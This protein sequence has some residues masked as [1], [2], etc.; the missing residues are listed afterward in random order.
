MAPHT[1]PISVQGITFQA[2]APYVAGHVLDAHEAQALNALL[3]ENLRNNWARRLKGRDL[4]PLTQLRFTAETK[5]AF[6]EELRNEFA[7]YAASYR[8]G[9]ATRAE[10][11]PV[12]REAQKI[13]H[14]LVREAV[15]AKGATPT[16]DEFQRRVSLVAA[17]PKVRAEAQRRVDVTRQTLAG[18]LDILDAE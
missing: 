18:A 16:P 15:N 6:V 13:A 4:G 12:A 9:H 17:L 1:T 3:A 10:R 8:L 14:A 7:A 11:D 5:A 2:P